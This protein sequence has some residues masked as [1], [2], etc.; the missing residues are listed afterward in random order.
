VTVYR[1]TKAFTFEASHTLPH[2]DGK[3]R[4]LHGHTWR[5]SLVV[6]GDRLIEEGPKTGMVVDYADLGRVTK[7]LHDQLDHRHLNDILDNPT[8]ELV[9]AW[10]YDQ[11]RSQ[12]EALGGATGGGRRVGDLQR[13]VRVPAVVLRPRP[14]H[15]RLSPGRFARLTRWH[16]AETAAARVAPPAART[17]MHGLLRF[18]PSSDDLLVRTHQSATAALAEREARQVAGLNV[19]SAA[20]L[21]IVQ[22]DENALA[23]LIARLE[24]AGVYA[25]VGVE[26]FGTDEEAEDMAE[27]IRDR[28]D[29]VVVVAAAVQPPQAG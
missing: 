12:V 26:V 5:C 28:T 19:S 8:S 27:F 16:P 17:P 29:S 6:D 9:A 2:H 20:G 10:V 1:L 3:C 24:A 25:P 18:R 11:A 4:N 23:A 7:S 15:V 21:L 14:T 13:G 22:G